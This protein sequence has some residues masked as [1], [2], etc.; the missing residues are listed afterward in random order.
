MNDNT[1]AIVIPSRIGSNRLPNKPLLNVAGKPLISWVIEAA[2]KVD[3]K[4]AV[5]GGKHE[6][7]PVTQDEY[8]GLVGAEPA[9]E[10]S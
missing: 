3:F 5:M 9:S 6:I 1:C 4:P 8:N 2:F 10:S 7:I